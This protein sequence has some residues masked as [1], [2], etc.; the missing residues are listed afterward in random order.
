VAVVAVLPVQAVRVPV[1]V[2]QAPVGRRAAVLAE[3]AAS[4]ALTCC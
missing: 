4:R 3:A 1:R 2:A